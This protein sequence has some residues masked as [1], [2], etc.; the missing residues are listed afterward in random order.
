M[1]MQ[2]SWTNT[3]Y[4]TL[5]TSKSSVPV[6]EMREAI[7]PVGKNVVHHRVP[8]SEGQNMVRNVMSPC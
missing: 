2:F 6:E 7:T 5:K 8:G 3:V 1:T 4:M